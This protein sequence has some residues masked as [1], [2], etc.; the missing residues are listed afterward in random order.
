MV[1]AVCCPCPADSK[2]TAKAHALAAAAADLSLLGAELQQQQAVVKR[3]LA[4]SEQLAEGLRHQVSSANLSTEE[5]VG[6]FFSVYNIAQHVAADR[7]R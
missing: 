6:H 3:Q 5:V 2:A 7:E 4:A 1:T